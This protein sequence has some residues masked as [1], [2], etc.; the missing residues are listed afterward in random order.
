MC[1]VAMEYNLRHLRGCM[2]DEFSVYG[3]AYRVRVIDRN[4]YFKVN[5]RQPNRIYLR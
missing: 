5:W 4:N 2:K 1:S 3:L